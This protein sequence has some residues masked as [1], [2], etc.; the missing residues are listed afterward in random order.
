[1]FSTFQLVLDSFQWLIP[2]DFTWFMKLSRDLLC[3]PWNETTLQML[4]RLWVSCVCQD[5]WHA[6]QVSEVYLHSVIPNLM[7][8]FHMPWFLTSAYFSVSNT[9]HH[10]KLGMVCLYICCLKMTLERSKWNFGQ[11]F[12][13]K[14]HD[15]KYHICP[16]KIG[17]TDFSLTFF[18]LAV[19]CFLFS[20]ATRHCFFFFLG[21]NVLAFFFFGNKAHPLP[22]WLMVCPLYF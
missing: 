8:H 16:V 10:L 2:N 20:L 22:R 17:M 15:V 19:T 21:N 7:G 12:A 1:M 6:W 4:H 13:R 5:S 9:L 14:W 11:R 3:W 18:S